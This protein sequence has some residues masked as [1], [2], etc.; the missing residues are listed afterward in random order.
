MKKFLGIILIPL[1]LGNCTAWPALT[2]V[3][4]LVGSNDKGSPIFIL[5]PG[6]SGGGSNAEG[7][8]PSSQL[9]PSAEDTETIDLPPVTLK[10]LSLEGK[11]SIPL[12]SEVEINLVGIYSNDTN[13]SLTESA[14]WTIA[15]NLILEERGFLPAAS[16]E[17]GNPKQIFRALN[18]GT[19]T[20]R[21]Q[22]G[23]L[24]TE[25][26]ITV[27]NAELVRIELDPSNITVVRGMSTPFHVTGFYTD[28]TTESLTIHTNTSFQLGEAIA[29]PNAP[30]EARI[31]GTSIGTTTLTAIH[32]T[33][34]GNFS[35]SVSLTVNPPDLET[36]VVNPSS[37]A[38]LA[39]GLDLDFSA[40]G[41]FE[42]GESWDITDDVIWHSGDTSVAN[43][44]TPGAPV[45]RI[46]SLSQ[47]TTSI[48][49]TLDG[50][51]SSTVNLTVVQKQLTGISITP[52]HPESPVGIPL[53]FTAIGSFTDGTTENITESATWFIPAED[54]HIANILNTGSNSG[55]AT[56]SS[57]GTTTIT[58]SYSSFSATSS[59]H[60]T[61]AVLQSLAITPE[62]AEIIAGDFRN[63][64]A[65]G[66]MSDS[67]SVDYTENVIWS[68]NN[69]TLAGISNAVGI[70]GRLQGISEG[71]VE[72]TATH[73]GISGTTNATILAADTT[74]PTL[75]SANSLSP[76]TVEVRFDKPMNSSQANSASN[77]KVVLS[78]S[79]SGSSCFD[80]SNFTTSSSALA[81]DSVSGSGD[82][83]V[84]TL[85]S[86]QAFGVNYT[87][88]ANKTGL[89][90]LA[91]TPNSLGCSNTASFEGQARLRVS[92]VSCAGLTRVVVNFS[93]P[94]ALGTSPGSAECTS[95]SECAT[96]YKLSSSLGSVTSARVLDGTVCGGLP[97]NPSR[98][99][100]AHSLLQG[101]ANYNVIGA[102]NE[103]G[104]GFDD[105]SYGSILAQDGE[106]L[107]S[108]PRDREGF[109]GCGITPNNFADGEIS[110][111]TFG[112]GTSFG[113]LTNYNGRIYVGPN[114][115]GNSA[116]RFQFDGSSP[117][118]VGFL[119]EKNSSGGR[120]HRNNASTRDGGTA[121][122]PFVTIGHS[123]CTSG[124]ADLTTGCGPDNENGRGT[125]SKLELFGQEFLFM[126]GARTVPGQKYPHFRYLYYTSDTGST[127]NFHW[128]QLGNLTGTSTEGSQSFAVLNNVL[129]AGFAKLNEPNSCTGM[130]SP[131]SSL[132]RNTP[133]FSKIRFR[134]TASG[135]GCRLGQNCEA[136]SQGDRIRIDAMDYLGGSNNNY[137]NSIGHATDNWGKYVGIDSLF[138]F[139]NR[140]YGANG[141]HHKI[142]HNGSIIRS[143]NTNPGSCNPGSNTCSDWT[144]IGPRSHP[145][146]HGSG[147]HENR[148]FS[149]EL[150]KASDFSPADH[151]FA[152]FAEHGN[153]LYVTRTICETNE[154]SAGTHSA[155]F[156][157]SEVPGC[158]DGSFGNRRPQLWKC[159]PTLTGNSTTC[160]AG[161]WE[162]VADN[163]TG[164]SN[165]GHSGNH[166]ATMVVA[167]GDYLYYGM[168]NENGVQ[169]WRTNVTNP[170]SDSSVWERINTD[171]F[172]DTD[173]RNIF[174]AISVPVGSQFFVYVSVGRNGTPL[175][176]FRQQNE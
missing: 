156:H 160:E 38:D 168:D 148:W 144:E 92:S 84:L 129:Y 42:N 1:F 95:I 104:D 82:T 110:S 71:S 32:T 157:M 53:D 70:R 132:S 139:N 52:S 27:T 51:S 96:K 61:P 91:T 153:N 78:N 81:I 150:R 73:S 118:N 54:S 35:D 67:S 170:G 173:M 106:S 134:N 30:S 10:Q 17:T 130:P 25:M 98:I 126:G 60:V 105:A 145:H 137:N 88:V 103:D 101:G 15:D 163:G 175:K 48:H 121:V 34:Y 141:G 167:N 74:P 119:I 158:T 152:Q 6:S 5:P 176:I 75:L 85:S 36:I 37:P 40:I 143:N 100:L 89:N 135:S 112:D 8:A 39:L 138:V 151:A 109:S 33:A 127:L 120:R 9:D 66:S 162:V 122:P 44:M 46:V 64:S 21:A 93:K 62:D 87:V 164:I 49:A 79:L 14:N 83:Y 142:N 166:S 12:G 58:A 154:S 43:F 107:Q 4:G 65:I 102:N 108:N 114:A 16:S 26:E 3:L 47:G 57:V 159:D 86:E 23:G 117:E 149:L 131:C 133:D 68:V 41:N 31:R 174:S 146:W 90:D 13:Q 165:F 69:S 77:Y 72:V 99:C 18:L 45:G 28:G 29:E 155:T 111:D 171:G 169:V 50:I 7:D 161:D 76:T 2:A 172:G 116:A 140:I 94:V 115:Q 24:E 80:N 55:R 125:F 56:G 59:F 113:Y 123:G 22:Y 20:L 147:I 97:S 11:T 128:I 19:T 124:T 63:F 136:Q